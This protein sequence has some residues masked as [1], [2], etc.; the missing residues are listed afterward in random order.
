MHPGLADVTAQVGRAGLCVVV[1]QA[2]IAVG[3][4]RSLPYIGRKEN[5]PCL[6]ASCPKT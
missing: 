6:S 1:E 2:R 4:A 5:R 3:R